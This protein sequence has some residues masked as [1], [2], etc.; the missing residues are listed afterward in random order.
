[1]SG[2]SGAMAARTGPA[3]PVWVRV[4]GRGVHGDPGDGHQGRRVDVVVEGELDGA[5]GRRAQRRDGVVHDDAPG[6]DDG[7]ALHDPLH[8]V[9]VVRGE[10]DRA[11]VGDGLTKERGEL[12]LQQRVEPGGGFVEDE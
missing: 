4:T 9:E 10:Q 1:M 3:A 2:C 7:D 11:A 6:P 5:R 12:V 8:L